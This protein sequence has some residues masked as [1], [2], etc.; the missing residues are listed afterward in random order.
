MNCSL[1]VAVPCANSD[2]LSY[3]KT[4]QQQQ[5]QRPFKTKQTELN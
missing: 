3:G 2:K 1:S 5:Q 4:K